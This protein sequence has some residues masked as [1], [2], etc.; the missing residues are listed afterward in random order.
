MVEI[1]TLTGG[2]GYVYVSW[3]VVHHVGHNYQCNIVITTDVTLSSVIMSAHV[4]DVPVNFYKFTG[5]PDDT[6]FNITVNSTVAGKAINVGS[7]VKT[8]IFESTYIHTIKFM[9]AI[10]I[11]HTFQI[12]YQCTYI[13]Y[14]HVYI[15]SYTKSI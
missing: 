13:I 15:C 3:T 14:V 10:T 4:V 7:T 2:C 12:M 8:M 6:I 1:T 9:C 11:N 5:L